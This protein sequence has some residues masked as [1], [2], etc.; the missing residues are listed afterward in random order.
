[1]GQTNEK[2]GNQGKLEKLWM[3]PYRIR[4]I[5]GKGSMWLKNLDEDELGFPTNGWH[6]KH[7][8]LSMTYHTSYS[9]C[10]A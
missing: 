8:F 6:L 7:Y 10:S 2:L 9:T 5:I 4:K 3:G 1:M